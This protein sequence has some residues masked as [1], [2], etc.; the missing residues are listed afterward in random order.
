MKYYENPQNQVYAFD[1]TDPTQVPLIEE[2]IKNGWLDISASY[3]IAP[4]KEQTIFLYEGVA[5]QNLDDVARSWGYSSMNTA[6]TYANSTNAQFKADAEALIAWRD[7]YWTK[8]YTI[9]A[10]TLP[11]TAEAFVGLLPKAPKQPVV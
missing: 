5:Q 9:E 10:G 11:A 3:P 2:A 1:E 4:T 6:V 7:K 8:A